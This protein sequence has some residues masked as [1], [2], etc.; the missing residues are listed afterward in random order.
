MMSKQAEQAV[1]MEPESKRERRR[2]RQARRF[3]LWMVPVAG[4]LARGYLHVP[5]IFCVWF[6]LGW[7]VE[8]ELDRGGAI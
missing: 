8:E 6:C 3:M 4:R 7:G 2:R 5:I 1:E